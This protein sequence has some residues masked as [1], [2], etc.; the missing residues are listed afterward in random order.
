VNLRVLEH[1]RTFAQFLLEAR[2]GS[3]LLGNPSASPRKSHLSM[4]V[5]TYRND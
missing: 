5:N 4:I 3:F 1:L 2:G